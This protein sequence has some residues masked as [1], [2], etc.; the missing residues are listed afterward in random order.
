MLHRIA[1]H[2]SALSLAARLSLLLLIVTGCTQ[3]TTKGKPEMYC[4]RDT[5]WIYNDSTSFPGIREAL[6][7]RMAGHWQ[8]RDSVP[9]YEEIWHTSHVNRRAEWFVLDRDG[10]RIYLDSLTYDIYTL[11]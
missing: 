9:V 5:F 8:G 2:F 11:F 10:R 6:N 3:R 7:D 1:S 4:E